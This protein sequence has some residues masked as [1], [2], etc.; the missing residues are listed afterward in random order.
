MA[1][2]SA[3]HSQ[4]GRSWA[5][6]FLAFLTLHRTP[7]QAAIDSAAWALAFVVALSVRYDLD[8]EPS[9]RV[10]F[11]V[12]LPAVL[13]VQVLVGFL[14]GLYRGRWRVGSFDEVAALAKAAA[15]PRPSSPSP[16]SSSATDRCP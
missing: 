16:T 4:E 7:A 3:V 2:Q 11:L 5:G 14:F 9:E 12:F 10:D 1:D 13:I 6:A 8:V 15:L